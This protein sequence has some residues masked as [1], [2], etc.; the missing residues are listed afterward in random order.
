MLG[1]L[2]QAPLNIDPDFRPLGLSYLP[3]GELKEA[4]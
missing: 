3:L 4:E 2:Y 1:E